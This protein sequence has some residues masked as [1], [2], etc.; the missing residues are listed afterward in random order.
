MTQKDDLGFGFLS[1]YMRR[2]DVSSVSI[3]T[4]IYVCGWSHQ[5]EWD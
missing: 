3:L 1:Y 4:F 2:Y 5:N